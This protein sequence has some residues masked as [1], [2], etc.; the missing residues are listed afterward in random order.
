MSKKT[1]LI[2]M[3]ERYGEALSLDTDL[4][5]DSFV[6]KRQLILNQTIITSILLLIAGFAL[7]KKKKREDK[8]LLQLKREEII[9]D[10]LKTK[11]R[12]LERAQM[13]F[14]NIPE[15]LKIEVK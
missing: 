9:L 10:K 13:G 2:D 12:C 6:T 14:K 7:K 15:C 4:K 11:Q 3:F 8:E 1:Y 5:L